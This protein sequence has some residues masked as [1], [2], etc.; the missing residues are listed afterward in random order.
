[1]SVWVLYRSMASVC[2]CGAHLIICSSVCVCHM[3]KNCRHHIHRT[4]GKE[5]EEIAGGM[6]HNESIYRAQFRFSP[7]E[8][9]Y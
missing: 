9:K 4:G 7:K 1:M 5:G 2:V 6:G 3:R 8:S